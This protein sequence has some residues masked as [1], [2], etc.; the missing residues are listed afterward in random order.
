MRMAKTSKTEE[1]QKLADGII[2]Q[3]HLSAQDVRCVSA[4]AKLVILNGRVFWQGR[5]YEPK[6]KSLGVGIYRVW[7]NMV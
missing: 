1:N 7:Y 5:T 6:T 4:V 3:I 2:R